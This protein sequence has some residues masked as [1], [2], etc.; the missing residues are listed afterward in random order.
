MTQHKNAILI[1][2]AVILFI[3]AGFISIF[4]S[5]LTKS[6]NIDQFEQKVYDATSLVTT[7]DTVEYKIKPNFDTIITL[8]NW[9]SKYI[10]EQ[11][12]FDA[13]LIQITTTPAA[14]FTK[15][16][17]IKDLYLKNVKYSDQTLPE[18]MNKLA[19]LPGSF[20]S[21]VFGANKITVIV[22]PVRVKNFNKV[23]IAPNVYQENNQREVKYSTSEVKQFLS[24][25]NF[26]H[27]NIK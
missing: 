9:S 26:A 13:R 12:C 5:I 3:Y 6:F 11:D 25:F 19:Y 14:L 24:Q 16:F 20:N 15:T 22:G 2:V 4:P 27:V 8:K 17:K 10:D 1:V 18:G 21:K 23:H 7:V